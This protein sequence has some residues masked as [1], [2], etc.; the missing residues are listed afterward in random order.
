[1]LKMMLSMINL[2]GLLTARSLHLQM[3]TCSPFKIR[4]SK[5]GMYLRNYGNAFWKMN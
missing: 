1:M 3:I 5:T 2:L 4:K